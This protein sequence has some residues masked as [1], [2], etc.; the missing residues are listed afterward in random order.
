M[1][2]GTRFSRILREERAY[3]DGAGSAKSKI[4]PKSSSVPVSSD[5]PGNF[6]SR[7]LDAQRDRLSELLYGCLAG[8]QGSA[9]AQL[10]R[11]DLVSAPDELRGRRAPT[12]G[13][14]PADAADHA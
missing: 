1:L 13:L 8:S 3:L 9:I 12:W 4:H 6:L 14:H 10:L 2:C 5:L 7:R 11:L